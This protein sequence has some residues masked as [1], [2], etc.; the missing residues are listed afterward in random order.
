M[1]V[2]SYTNNLGVRE[3]QSTYVP[4]PFEEMYTVLQEKQKMY[5]KIDEYERE[6]KKYVTGLNS[7]FKAHADYLENFKAKYLKDALNLHNSMPD[8]GSALYERKLNEMV[9]GYGSDPNLNIINKSNK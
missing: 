3:R 4:L 5:D 2:N 7:P 6:Q 9:E 8:K 1:G